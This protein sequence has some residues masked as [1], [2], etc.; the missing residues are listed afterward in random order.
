M[1]IFEARRN[2]V[3]LVDFQPAYGELG[4]PDYYSALSAAI[5]YINKKQPKVLAFFNGTDVG[6][7]DT[8]DEVIWHYIENGLD[9][10]LVHLFT[11]R[12]KSY[13]W[14]RGWMDDGVPESIIIKV[15][16]YMVT[17]RINDSRDIDSEIIEELTGGYDVP[18]NDPLWIPDISLSELKSLNNS[19]MGGGGRHECLKELTLFMN[20]LNIKYKLVNSW[21][22]G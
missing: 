17:N 19:L 5:E 8:E 18:L 15:V 12:E 11:L 22:Y 9:E 4:T 16:R 13:A 14:L 7:Y 20:A 10:N 1:K 6:I 2:S 3:I 21:I